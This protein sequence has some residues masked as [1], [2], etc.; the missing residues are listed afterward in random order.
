VVCRYVTLDTH[1]RVLCV[2]AVLSC[3][4]GCQAVYYLVLYHGNLVSSDRGVQAMFSQIVVHPACGYLARI[5]INEKFRPKSPRG[6]QSAAS[7]P[8]AG[9]EIALSCHQGE[10]KGVR[11]RANVKYLCEIW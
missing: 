2:C 3:L 9:E 4:R 10:P 11:D 6:A 1:P 5:R 8:P 7:G